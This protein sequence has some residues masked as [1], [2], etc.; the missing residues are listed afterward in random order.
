MTTPKSSGG[1]PLNL[2]G[3]LQGL[4]EYLEKYRAWTERL[5]RTLPMVPLVLEGEMSLKSGKLT[6]KLLPKE[7]FW[8]HADGRTVV[9]AGPFPEGFF[10]TET[11]DSVRAAST[12]FVPSMCARPST[13]R[14]DQYAKVLAED[15]LDTGGENEFG[16]VT[17]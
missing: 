14:S 9:V 7:V 8:R 6:R 2:E 12:T 17:P 1:P 5:G 15:I 11:R 3:K 4:E 16:T 13:T 10:R